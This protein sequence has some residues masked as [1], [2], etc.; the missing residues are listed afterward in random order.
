MA[1][2]IGPKS[3]EVSRNY[4]YINA[5]LPTHD[6]FNIEPKKK[7]NANKT[8]RKTKLNN[9]NNDDDIKSITSTKVHGP[10][11]SKCVTAE[12]TYSCHCPVDF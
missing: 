9:N 8:T 3:S 10:D 5:C 1:H 6:Q 4:N 11:N 2:E 12:K 7:K